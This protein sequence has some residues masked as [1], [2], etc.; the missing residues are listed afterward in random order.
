MEKK[1]SYIY[2]SLGTLLALDLEDS[3]KYMLISKIEVSKRFSD[4]M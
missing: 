3:E 1:V 2:V 4:N